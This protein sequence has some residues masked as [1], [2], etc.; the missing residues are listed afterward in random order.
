MMGRKR[1]EQVLEWV[2]VRVSDQE[3][4]RSMDVKCWGVVLDDGLKWH[5]HI[6]QVQ[7]NV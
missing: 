7:R 1:R 4:G 5:R 2:K 6:G 3:I